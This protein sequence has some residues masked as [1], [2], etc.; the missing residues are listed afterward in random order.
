[1]ALGEA[2]QHQI[3]RLS[4]DEGAD[5]REALAHDEITFPVPGHGAVVGLGRALG[6]HD[7]VADLAH[8]VAAF[9]PL[10]IAPHG[11][12][13]AQTDVQLVAQGTPA[14]DEDRR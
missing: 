14:L 11:P 8:A 9:G 7:H 6:D 3:A 13:T 1:V 5:R 10:L 2:D 4:F 12:A